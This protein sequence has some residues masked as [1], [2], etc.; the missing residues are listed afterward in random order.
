MNDDK[1]EW[2]FAS[3]DNQH[4]ADRYDRWA[5]QY[6]AD[7]DGWEWIGPAKAVE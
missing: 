5:N 4:L 3:G 7:H 6:D 2:I 1:L